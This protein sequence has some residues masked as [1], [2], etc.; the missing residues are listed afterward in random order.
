MVNENNTR[1]GMA[2]LARVKRG[3]NTLMGAVTY[4][5]PNINPVAVS[6]SVRTPEGRNRLTTCKKRVNSGTGLP[7]LREAVGVLAH[8]IVAARFTPVDVREFIDMASTWLLR[9]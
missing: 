3:T 1:T 9:E 8:E 4:S 6:V 5:Y 7:E 2:E